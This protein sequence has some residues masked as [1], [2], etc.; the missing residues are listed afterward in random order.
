MDDGCGVRA[1]LISCP[2]PDCIAFGLILH[3]IHRF[4]LKFIVQFFVPDLDR[5]YHIPLLLSR[6]GYT[7]YRGS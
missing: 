5:H 4:S 3:H 2:K 6:F 1:Q 7:T